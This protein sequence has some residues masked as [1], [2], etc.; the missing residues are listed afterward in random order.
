MLGGRGPGPGVLAAASTRVF[1]L[2][3]GIALREGRRWL[4]TSRRGV[5]E[6][7]RAGVGAGEFWAGLEASLS[8]NGSIR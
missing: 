6:P 3:L 4:C 2:F 7:H 8:G 1:L 5:G